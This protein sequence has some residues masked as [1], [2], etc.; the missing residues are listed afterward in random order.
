MQVAEKMH[1][2]EIDIKGEIPKHILRFLKNN[3][4]NQ[5]KI[6][7]REDDSLVNIRDSTWYK[8]V[9]QKMTPAKYMKHLRES[10]ELSQEHL[11]ELL[12]NVSRQN[13]SNMENG[14]RGISKDKAIKL[15][16]IFGIPVDRFLGI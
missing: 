4:G 7:S 1:H 10:R 11:G 6:S 15:S 12:G 9:K 8:N 16:K 14:K 13:V 3:F 2:I 5:M